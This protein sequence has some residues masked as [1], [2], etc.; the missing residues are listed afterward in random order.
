MKAEERKRRSEAAQ[1]AEVLT[2]A[3]P[4]I[5]KMNGRTVVVKYG[6]AAMENADLMRQVV[7]DLMLMKLMGLRI[8]LVHGGGKAINALLK[9]LDIP[10][11]FER[12]LRVT[13]DQTMEAVQMVLI[14]KVNQT[15]VRGLNAYGNV[16]V[17]ISGAD[18]MTF[19]VEQTDPALGRVGTITHVN[20]EL[21][22]SVLD[23]GYIPV[24]AS[25][26]CGED[27]FYNIN[28]DVAA[29]EVA[30]ALGAD[31]LVY[32]TDVD[33]LFRDVEDEESLISQL[34]KSE[35]EELLGSGTLS[36]GM[37]PKI[38]S[39]VEAL[40]GGVKEVHLLNGTFPHALLLEVFTD[41][42]IG[43]MVAQDEE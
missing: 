28:A 26:G 42:G 31:K 37:I 24:I 39:V 10:V 33:G 17:G 36:A 25:V 8:V 2:E 21:I 6:G 41:A 4:W 3:L 12:G 20:T 11:K 16:G 13:D 38:S 14:G 9:Q 34:T 29:S 15:L 18:G 32:L 1:K 35:A 19:E 5:N 23:D 7:G 40:K 27:G 43:T 22:E 30:S